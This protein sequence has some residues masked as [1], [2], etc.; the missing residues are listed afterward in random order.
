MYAGMKEIADRIIDMLRPGISC[1]HLYDV[2]CTLAE[3]MGMSSYFMRIGNDSNKVPFIGHGVG[4]EVNEPPLL[5]KDNQEVLEEGM[6]IAL[7]LEMCG[8][9]GEVVK[10]EDML[11]ITSEGPE[12][13][14]ITP[15][16]LH[17]I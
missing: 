10:L 13:L 8:A 4:L 12:F 15:R 9:V 14:T 3:N 11:L 2:A 5:G 6:I 1:T 17:Q 7:E 16:D